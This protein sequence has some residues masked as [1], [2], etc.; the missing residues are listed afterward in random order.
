M[1]KLVIMAAGFIMLTASTQAVN[2][3]SWD[4]TVDLGAGYSSAW[5]VQMYQD[6]GANSDLSLLAFDTSAADGTFL[7]VG[8]GDDDVLLGVTTALALSKGGIPPLTWSITNVDPGA[9]GIWVYSVI[10]NAASIGGATLGRIIDSSTW[11]VAAEGSY[12]QNSVNQN[13]QA[14][15]EP[16]TALLFGIGGMGAFIVRRNKQ[17]A[18]E[19]ADA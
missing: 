9:A 1:K 18:Q 3:A 15:P 11:T 14:V 8:N 5:L 12:S 7:S 10:F 16:A 4:Y 17:K 2:V 19:E 13:W 6:V